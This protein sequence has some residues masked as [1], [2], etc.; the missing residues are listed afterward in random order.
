MVC[1]LCDV[2]R[3][4]IQ[5]LHSEG[6]KTSFLSIARPDQL[7]LRGMKEE[8]CI[9]MAD[10]SNKEEEEGELHFMIPTDIPT[11]KQTKTVMPHSVEK[12][13]SIYQVVFEE[14]K[15]LPPKRAIDHAIPGWNQTQTFD[16]FPTL[17]STEKAGFLIKKYS[18][19][20]LVILGLSVG[21]FFFTLRIRSEPLESERSDDMHGYSLSS[22]PYGY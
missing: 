6:K 22:H 10:M 8:K 18:S 15:A 13:L 9:L 20:L 21:C 4:C 1:Y 2:T 12:V 16:T 19:F 17:Y 14:P 7:M 5:L 3:R 11:H